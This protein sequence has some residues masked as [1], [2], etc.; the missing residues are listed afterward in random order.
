MNR[1]RPSTQ[2]CTMTT[3]N[4]WHAF[5]DDLPRHEDNDILNNI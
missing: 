4:E 3:K 2:S 5:V 1:P